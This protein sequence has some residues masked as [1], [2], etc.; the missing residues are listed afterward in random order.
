MLYR[1]VL[2]FQK[3]IIDS[4]E[5]NNDID[6]LGKKVIQFLAAVHDIGKASPAFQTQKGYCH[7][8]DLDLR[9]LE[10]LERNGFEGISS[11]QLAKPSKSHHSIAGQY[12]LHSYGVKEDISTIIGGHHDKPID[13]VDHYKNQ[14]LS[15]PSNYFQ[16]QDSGNGI[17]K[18]WKDKQR[19]IF[20]WALGISGFD[21]VE[22]LPKIRQPAQVILSGLLIMADW[23]ASNEYYFPLLSIDDIAVRHPL[24]RKILG[25]E[26]WKKTGLWEPGVTVNF[27]R[28]YEKRFDFQPRNVQMVLADTIANTRNP[29][30]LIL[31]AP[32]GIGKTEA[33]LV[34]AEQLAAK[35]GR[36][37]IF[38]GLPTQATSNGIFSRIEKWLESVQGELEENLSIHLVHGKAQLNEDFSCLSENINIDD[39]DNGSVI[40]NEWFS[41]KKTTSLDDFVVGTVDQMLMVALK[42]KHLALRHLGFSRKVVII[43]EVHT[44]DA[45][46][47]Q[48]LLEVLRWMGAYGVPVIILSATLPAERRVEL[49]KS[50]MFGLG[51]EFNKTERKQL[52]HELKTDA[53][54]LITYNNGTEVCQIKEFQESKHKRIIIEKLKEDQLLNLIKDA[55]RDG[56]VIGL[57]VNT[58]KRAQKLAQYFAE[59]LGEDMVELLHSGFIATHRAQKEKELLQMIGKKA[60]RPKQKIII[61][62]QVIEQ[63][64]DIDFDMLIS[65]LAP[66]DLLIQRLGRLHRH[67]D[68][69][70]PAQHEQPHCY[71]LGTSDQLEFE[72]GSSFVYGDYL[73]ARTQYFLPDS[74]NLPEAIS[75][76]VQKVYEFDIKSEDVPNIDIDEVL[77][78]KYM[79]GRQKYISKMEEKKSKAKNY[80]I[81]NPVLK[82]SRKR[83]ENL[84]GWLKNPNPDENEE[85][86]YAQVRDI[87]DTIEVIAL[88]KINDGYGLFGDEKDI[89]ADIVEGDLAKQV[90]QNTLRLPLTLS[91]FY[92]VDKTIEELERYYLKHFSNWSSSPWL[93]GSLGIIFDD[94]NEFIIKGFK[95]IYDEKYGIQVERM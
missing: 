37:G 28:L 72:E 73:L 66:M 5:T 29:G 30:I 36:N 71:V 53:Y 47:N 58:V 42:Q 51:K 14:G 60:K 90:A 61:G 57:I 40:V 22:S 55:L 88:K 44:Y 38:F 35:T 46:M 64:L 68:I 32:M 17:N 21:S 79:E 69:K 7:S 18:K 34:A 95:L 13:E 70:R 87:E 81:A 39:A 16:I 41:G 91:K 1:K 94:N 63:S 4:L 78:S 10:R 85:K 92:N 8:E 9:L 80:R 52:A 6:N 62:T 84:I 65:D 20:D 45:Y 77:L 3:L 74:I 83:S 43:D 25:F 67:D 12:L 24:E 26:K 49:L 59:K 76:L 82:P 93:K 50:Y 23:I 11:L 31:E 15:Y 56:G 75:P 33:A 54:P 19:S 89:S 86:A 48:Y 27:N 2:P